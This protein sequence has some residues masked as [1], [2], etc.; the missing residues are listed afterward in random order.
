M[1]G[2]AA[3]TTAA[4]GDVAV[5]INASFSTSSTTFVNAFSNIT[6]VT[7][8]I[9]PVMIVMIPTTTG[10]SQ[11]EMS[12]ASVTANV[13]Y[14]LNSN[15]QLLKN[16]SGSGGVYTFHHRAFSNALTTG[17]NFSI[18]TGAMVFY[19]FP[20]AGTQTYNVQVQFFSTTNTGTPSINVQGRLMAFEI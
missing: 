2:R 9:R 20:T 5:S 1:A 15:I 19:D 4:L 6:L 12:C 3:S 11:L 13:R 18:P 8:G 17:I 14:V 16:G 10:V 7:S